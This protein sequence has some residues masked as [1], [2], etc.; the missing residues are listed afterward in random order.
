MN[1]TNA[2]IS[3]HQDIRK[4]D[5][6]LKDIIPQMDKVPKKVPTSI[7]NYQ[8]RYDAVSNDLVREISKLPRDERFIHNA[9][10]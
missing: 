4:Q 1:D 6:Y 7:D 2:V 5:D 9:D 10:K 3:N 8:G